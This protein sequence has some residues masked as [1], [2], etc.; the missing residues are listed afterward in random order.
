MMKICAL[1]LATG[2]ACCLGLAAPSYAA[3]HLVTAG[4]ATQ[5]KLDTTSIPGNNAP[6]EGVPF[7]GEDTTVPATDQRDCCKSPFPGVGAEAAPNA[8]KFK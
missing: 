7:V 2:A 8:D 1:F 4:I 3:D 6:G 5:G